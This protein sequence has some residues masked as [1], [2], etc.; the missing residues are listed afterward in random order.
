MN[1]LFTTK[2]DQLIM[3]M[4]DRSYF[5]THEVIEWGSKNYYNRAAQTKG[6]LHREGFVRRLNDDEKL[7]RGF[8]CKD[9]AYEWMG[10]CL[11]NDK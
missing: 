9:D 8:K 1:D 7:F 3:W 10:K 2:K 11:E 4:R 5:A 6:D